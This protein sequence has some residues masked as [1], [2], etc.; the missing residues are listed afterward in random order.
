MECKQILLIED[1]RDLRETLKLLLELEGFR[2]TAAQ[3]GREGLDLLDDRT[4]PC[5]IVLDLMMPIMSGWEFLETIKRERH[6][7]L[8]ATALLVITAAADV[9]PYPTDLGCRV[10]KKPFDVEP[11]LQIARQHCC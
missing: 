10:L 2:V 8:T 4:P 1:E 5:L 3:N 6:T 11:L 7:L 9:G